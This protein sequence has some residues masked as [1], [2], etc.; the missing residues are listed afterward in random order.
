MEG[1]W[2]LVPANPAEDALLAI[3]SYY[4][5]ATTTNV[6]WSRKTVQAP[7]AREAIVK[8][9]EEWGAHYVVLGARGQNLGQVRSLRMPVGSTCDYVVR[10]APCSTIV[11]R[12]N[13]Q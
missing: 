12:K 10:N 5:Q 3:V 7:D 11:V 8:E 9:A 1:S 13:Q 4:S 2:S 6:Q